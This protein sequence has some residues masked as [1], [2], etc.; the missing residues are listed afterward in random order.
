MENVGLIVMEEGS[1]WP[2]QVGGS[3]NVLVFVQNDG[4]FLERMQQRLEALESQGQR[5]RVAV[6]ACNGAMDRDACER[7]RFVGRALLA[8]VA[9][10]G[11]G[12]LVLTAHGGS[13]P[14]FPEELLSLTDTLR[15]G[16]NGARVM[17]SLRVSGKSGECAS[18]GTRV[19]RRVGHARI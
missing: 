17:V 19:A 2:G 10:A 4:L 12:R 15:A 3:A 5:V 6:L 13:S 1:E 8:V 18:F 7:R 11:F 9:R 16:V 14:H